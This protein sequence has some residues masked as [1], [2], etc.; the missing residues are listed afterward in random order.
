LSVVYPDTELGSCLP[1]QSGVDLIAHSIRD[2]VLDQATIQLIK[3][4]QIMYIPTL[5]L[6]EFA[7]IYARRPDWINDPFFKASLETGVNEMITSKAYQNKLKD[8]QVY[9]KNIRAF[10][11]AMTN[12]K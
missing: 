2:T 6:D 12:L 10:E 8:S 1:H 3:D 11:T 4:K 9:V 7:F 5:S